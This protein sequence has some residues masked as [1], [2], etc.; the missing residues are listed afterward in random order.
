MI[1]EERSEGECERAGR[2]DKWPKVQDV[3][4]IKLVVIERDEKG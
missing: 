2:D 1:S 4:E 3:E